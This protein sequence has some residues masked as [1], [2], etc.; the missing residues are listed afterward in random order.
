MHAVH[1]H[2]FALGIIARTV[3]WEMKNECNYYLYVKLEQTQPKQFSNSS[4]T[5]LGS[6]S[7]VLELS[8]WFWF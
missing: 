6:F 5:V 2:P 7:I 1:V 3:G 8:L 4:Q